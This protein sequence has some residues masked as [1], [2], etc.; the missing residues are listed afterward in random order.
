MSELIKSATEIDYPAC[1][2]LLFHF[3]Y[4]FVSVL[5]IETDILLHWITC[6]Q[7]NN[8]K[9][10]IQ[11]EIKCAIVWVF[12]MAFLLWNVMLYFDLLR[13]RLPSLVFEVLCRDRNNGV[14]RRRLSAGMRAGFRYLPT[15]GLLGYISFYLFMILCSHDRNDSVFPG[16]Q[17]SQK[18]QFFTSY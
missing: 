9:I 1:R 11:K 14:L 13:Q 7:L 10:T 17:C 3:Q 12:D 16:I 8:L 2:L 6:L 15:A 4:L 18:R 5:P